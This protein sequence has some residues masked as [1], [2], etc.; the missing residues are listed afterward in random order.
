MV[1]N[2]EAII[3]LEDV[4]ITTAGDVL[5]RATDASAGDENVNTDW[6]TAGGAITFSATDQ[7]LSG[8]VSI[9]ELSSIVMTLSGS[10]TLTGA[11]EVEDGG[12]ATI[13]LEGNATWT[14][15]GESNVDSLDGV[16]FS[17]STP[18]NVDA[19]SGVVIYY[20]SATDADGKALSGTYTLAGGGTL[21]E[22]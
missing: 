13:V 7:V 15:T 16:T 12:S 5:I 17:G 9:N 11:V 21:V 1:L 10:T 14:A 4:D 20:S 8:T 19:E 6:G 22:A 2:T 3:T 18:T